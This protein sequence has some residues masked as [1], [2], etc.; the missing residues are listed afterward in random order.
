MFGLEGLPALWLLLLGVVWALYLGLGGTDLGVSMLLRRMPDRAAA[1]RTNGATWATNDVWLVIAVAATFGAFPGWYAAW[2][3][4][5]YGVLVVLILALIVRHAGTELMGHLDE[6]SARWWTWAIV[7]SAW[8]NAIGW[9][10]VWAWL[11]EGGDVLTVSTVL[12]GVGLALVCRVAGAAYLERRLEDGTVA[13]VVRRRTVPVA[14]VLA[15]VAGVALQSPWTGLVV[16]ALVPRLALWSAGLAAA[17]V[18]LAVLAAA[19]PN[20]AGVDLRVEA[21]GDYTL[22]LMTVIAAVVLPLILLAHALAYSRFRRE[23][24]GLVNLTRRAMEQLR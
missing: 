12:G 14:L 10:I 13:A 22:T 8:V 1:L 11:L 17:I 23:P 16:L 5:L 9:G 7:G 15:V 3:S 2:M 6:R 24:G 4:G 21:A 20:V 18:P 19:S